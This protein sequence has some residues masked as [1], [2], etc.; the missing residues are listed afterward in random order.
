MKNLFVLFS[1]FYFA[2]FSLFGQ[3]N[4]LYFE[5]Q[6]AK[7]GNGNFE[8]AFLE[9]VNAELIASK[10]FINPDEVYFFGNISLDVKQNQSKAINLVMPLKSEN[11]TLELIEAPE[12]FYRYEVM[13]SSGKKFPAN[14]DIKHYRG[15]VKG[16]ENSLVAITFYED[17]I[18][19]LICTDEGNFNLVKDYQSGKH[20]FYNE[21]NLIEKSNMTC[22]TID[23]FTLSYDPE[24][25][26]KQRNIMS[27][28]SSVVRTR[29]ID[30]IV[31]FYVETEYDIYQTRGNISSVEA[32][33]AGLFNQVAV[34]YLNEDI[35]T[36]VSRLYIWD[37]NDPY[38][39]TNLTPLLS[40]FQTIRTSIIGDMGILL[41]FRNIGGGLA[42]R[43][44][45]LCNVPTDKRLA[46]AKLKNHDIIGPIYSWSVYVVTH[47]LGHLF[48]SRHTH[49]CVWNGDNTAIDGCPG[50][51]ENTV[52]DIPYGN[53]PV[54]AKPPAGTIM[55]YCSEDDEDGIDFI[56][57]FGHQPGNVIRN[58]VANANCLNPCNPIYF[59]NQTVTQ[60]D[61][62]ISC[63]D[64]LV[65]NVTVTNGATL[66]LKAVGN[67][68]VQVVIVK[69]NSK[70]ILDAGGEVNIISEFEVELG[71]EFEIK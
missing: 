3:E 23:D 59:T 32:Y 28:D 63:S 64:I 11:I 57:G 4:V 41:T 51:T 16:K 22:G 45:G 39:G 66:T 30:K 50:Y 25:L 6:Q 67:I 24:V 35:F 42:A 56:L 68:D 62:N 5:V 71:S 12:S 36:Y 53:C 55:S 29:I 13:T 27:E 54:P 70:L 33:I 2:V 14:K 37:A 1:T 49:A 10:K 69:N 46:V 17:E 52:L 20:L 9:E 48:G 58:N 18:I 60:E 47:E 44:S 15:I 65:Q 8:N 38:T 61:N 40:Q 43:Y 34:L 7:K 31:G 21:R 19:G 26:L